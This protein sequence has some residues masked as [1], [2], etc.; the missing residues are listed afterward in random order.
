MGFGP[1]GGGFDSA[2]SL[3]QVMFFL[4]FALI[5]VMFIVNI[6]KY[7]RN[8]SAPQESSYAR[9]VSKRTEVRSSSNHHHNDNMHMGSSSR[10]YYFITLEFD[11]GSRKEY[12]DVKGLY[13]LVAEGDV[14]Y[15][16]VKGDWIVAFQRQAGEQPGSGNGRGSG[17]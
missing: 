15:A 8:A 6:A 12:L 4:V 14:G 7:F 13:G 5:I 3:F 10:T 11:N 17:Y 9:I 1:F 16:A 2:F